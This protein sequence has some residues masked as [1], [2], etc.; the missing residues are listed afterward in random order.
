MELSL[1]SIIGTTTSV[2]QS[3]GIARFEVHARQAGRRK[4]G[5]DESMHN[6]NGQFAERNDR[7]SRPE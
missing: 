2:A 3:S 5:N 7:Q 1:V 4:R 6:L